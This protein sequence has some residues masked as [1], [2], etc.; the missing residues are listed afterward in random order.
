MKAIVRLWNKVTSFPTTVRK[1]VKEFKEL[2]RNEFTKMPKKYNRMVLLGSGLEGIIELISRGFSFLFEC[3]KTAIEKGH[4]FWGVV[5]LV[6]YFTGDVIKRGLRLLSSNISDKLRIEEGNI[7]DLN[8]SK[9]LMLARNKVIDKDKSYMPSSKILEYSGN[10]ISEIASVRSELLENL[11][12]FIIAIIMIYGF[13]FVSNTEI[14]DVGLFIVIIST[15]T[16]VEIIC[17]IMS[18]RNFRKNDDEI[19]EIRVEETAI[20]NDVINIEPIN[21]NHASFIINCYT[22]IKIKHAE[23]GRRVFRKHDKYLFL[24]TITNCL[25]VVAILLVKIDEQGFA[26]VNL[27]TVTDVIAMQTIY[28]NLVGSIGSLISSF[29]GITRKYR[30]IK[31]RGEDVRE[32]FKAVEEVQNAQYIKKPVYEVPA[33]KTE[34]NGKDEARYH[35]ENKQRF[36][37]S[38]EDVVILTGPT[39]S[40]K[41]TLMKLLTSKIDLGVFKEK[42][43]A[44]VQQADAH[45]G[46]QNVLDELTL[47]DE[48]YD[49][50][51]LTSILKGLHLYEEI[52]A[53]NNEGVLCYLK[54]ERAS[55]FSTGQQQRFQI[56]RMLY[57]IDDSV[58]IIAFDEATSALNDAIAEQVMNYIAA[59]CKGKLVLMATHQVNLAK[60]IAT[61]HLEFVADENEEG[62]FQIIER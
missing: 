61:K 56:A 39:G 7:K 44:I 19:S 24:K 38:N 53:P 31:D 47:G 30:K 62:T 43:S 18:N 50:G 8:S 3:S 35:L 15:T 29:G 45:L 41:S 16:I 36:W 20:K 49:E 21:E 28:N 11:F 57:N 6:A 60:K 54:H 59:Y 27:K 2:P 10:Y 26:N 55:E 32:I 13:V 14:N 9:I 4:I 23:L 48:S 52:K 51:K 22:K 17:E 1:S 25:A 33:F 34:Y 40:G 5:A 58:G 12:Q 46:S 42:Y 37:L